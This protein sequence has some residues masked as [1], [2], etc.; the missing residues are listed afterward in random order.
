MILQDMTKAALRAADQINLAILQ[1][2][3]IP[4]PEKLIF[5]FD[6]YKPA[7]PQIS[8]LSGGLPGGTTPGLGSP[9][10]QPGS[11]FN[12]IIAPNARIEAGTLSA[13]GGFPGSGLSLAG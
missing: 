4:N 12:S 6:A 2:F 13:P 7:A 9:N 5:N 8:P 10:G 3:D 1:A 11:E